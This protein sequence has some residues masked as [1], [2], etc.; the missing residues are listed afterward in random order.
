MQTE[1]IKTYNSPVS[2]KTS[3]AEVYCNAINNISRLVKVGFF[4]PLTVS[5]RRFIKYA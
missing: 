4:M 3:N 1:K 5:D 2:M